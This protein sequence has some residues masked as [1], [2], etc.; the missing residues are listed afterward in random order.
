MTEDRHVRRSGDDYAQ[1]FATFLPYG[2]A[3][4]REQDSVLMQA[5]DGLAQFYGYVD[6][7]AADLL[8]QESDPRLTYELLPDWERN[9]GLPDPCM[10]QPKTLDQRRLMLV[11]RMTLLGA[12]SRAFYIEVASWLGYTI[13]IEELSPI[14]CGVSRCAEDFWELGAPEIRYYWI[15]H[16]Y[17]VPIWWFRCAVGECGKNHHAEWD[18]LLDLECLIRRWKPAHTVVIF[19]YADPAIP[20]ARIAQ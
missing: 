3:W 15:I 2:Q 12:Q 14:M 16:I 4:P 13:T 19:D 1:A 20:P 6:S 9:W 18:P 8:E 17:G 11:Q 7:R 5:I 10:R